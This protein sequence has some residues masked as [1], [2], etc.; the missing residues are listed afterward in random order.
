MRQRLLSRFNLTV[1]GDVNCEGGRLV[2]IGGLVTI[3][4]GPNSCG[5]YFGELIEFFITIEKYWLYGS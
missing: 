1:I 2:T 5:F 4:Y 3:R